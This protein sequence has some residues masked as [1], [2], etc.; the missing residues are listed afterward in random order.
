MIS[1][2]GLQ[3]FIDL[4]EKKYFIKLPRKEAFEMFSQLVRMVKLANSPDLAN[5]KIYDT[6]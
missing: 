5:S 1:E 6:I 3:E 2:Q 4:Y